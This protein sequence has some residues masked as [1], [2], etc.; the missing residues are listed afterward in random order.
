MKLVIKNKMTLSVLSITLSLQVLSSLALADLKKGLISVN[1]DR[2]VAYESNIQD[3]NKTTLI[4]MPG[5]FRGLGSRTKDSLLGLLTNEKMNWVAYHFSG[6]PESIIQSGGKNSGIESISTADLAEETRQVVKQ[7]K[8]KKPLIISLSYSSTAASDLTSKDAKLIVETAPLG[9]QDESNQMM[10]PLVEA[11]N[12]LCAGAFAQFNPYCLAWETQKSL[13]Y[14]TYWSGVVSS[15]VKVYPEL[16]DFRLNSKAVSGYVGMAKA[17]ESYDFS[18]L[19]FKAGPERIFILGE[20]EE[21]GRSQIQLAAI[22]AY[23]EQRGNYP[24]VFFVKSAGHIV[25][26][27]Q[28]Q[29]YLKIL[30]AVIASDL[31]KNSPLQV[32]TEK[33]EFL[34]MSKDTIDN[35]FK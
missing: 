29:A 7:L 15:L 20:N 12:S 26:V 31:P 24:Y 21:S 5:I 8:V 14:Q 11:N 28:P 19:N 4:L 25:P 35:L 33:G 23:K 34:P 2:S 27:D 10:S 22:K 1:S 30:N 32:V 6:H 9:R 13:A 16:S 3:E 17:V 18:K